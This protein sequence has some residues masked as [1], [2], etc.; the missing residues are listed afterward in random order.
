MPPHCEW[1]TMVTSR[2]RCGPAHDRR[3]APAPGRNRGYRPRIG[4]RGWCPVHAVALL[5]EYRC[6]LGEVTVHVRGGAGEEDDRVLIRGTRKIVHP[7]GV[8]AFVG[9]GFNHRRVE[10]IPRAERLP[11]GE[12]V[13]GVL[14]SV[15][16]QRLRVIR[17][18]RQHRKLWI[19]TQAELGGEP[20][21][22][23]GEVAAAIAKTAVRAA[24]F[25]II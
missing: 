11:R 10:I 4:W 3:R 14:G 20:G 21:E 1:P 18:F 7:L 22:C 17:S 16:G 12:A 23:G 2:P 24:T 25:F 5:H 13:L 9:Q 6:H 8:L 19:R 15:A